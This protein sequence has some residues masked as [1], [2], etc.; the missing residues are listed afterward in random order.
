MNRQNH[1][2]LFLLFGFLS[3]SFDNVSLKIDVEII[4]SIWPNHFENH[5]EGEH[6]DVIKVKDINSGNI[7]LVVLELIGDIDRKILI[8]NNVFRMEISSPINSY[9]FENKKLI[10]EN[11]KDLSKY[12][13]HTSM[14]I[15]SLDTNTNQMNG[16]LNY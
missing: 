11:P 9:E 5:I 3:Y 10:L 1:I 2:F 6:L 13:I 7:Y 14:N 12:S 15:I 8:K 16:S 4:D